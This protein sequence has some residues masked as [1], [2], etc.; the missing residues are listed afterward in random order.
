M[1]WLSFRAETDEALC[2]VLASG[3]YDESDYIRNADEFKQLLA[4]AG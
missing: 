2:M 4:G 1:T 3:P